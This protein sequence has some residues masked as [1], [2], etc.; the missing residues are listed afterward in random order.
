MTIAAL[1]ALAPARKSGE[2]RAIPSICSAHPVVIAASFATAL[3]RGTPILIEATCN[4]VNHE[5][6]Y[7]GMTP[8]D[9]RAY[10]LGIAAVEGFDP[11]GLILGGDHLGPNPWTALPAAAAMA[12][13]RDMV[14]GYAQAG[15][16]KIHLDASMACADDPKPLPDA[17]IAA[18][19]AELAAV[20]EA[21]APT[22]PVYIIGTEVPVPGGAW[23][24]VE[25]L[26]PTSSQAALATASLQRA[27]FAAAGIEAAFARVVG[28]VVQPGVEFGNENVVAYDRSA[29]GDLISILPQ[30]PMLFEAHSTDYQTPQALADLVQDGFGILKVGPGLTFALREALYGLDHIA[31]VLFP[32]QPRLQDA[33][34]MLMLQKPLYWAK[35]YHGSALH[36]HLQRHYSYSDRIRYY[37]TDPVASAAVAGLLARFGDMEI[38]EPLISQHLGA[39]YPDV[40]QGKLAKTA[41]ALLRAAVT[42]ALQPYFDACYGKQV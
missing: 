9:F 3:A 14:A 13:A 4:Q 26:V 31:D 34:E 40:M 21:H 23:E 20:A 12:K 16:A 18:R 6:G 8:A 5:G 28:L 15:F 38:P 39:A 1:L 11:A 42:R 7:T 32:D 17:T 2:V 35:Y 25:G 36:Q 41:P 37:W 10:V 24:E 29:A 19:N 22:P 33:M 27:A 30:L